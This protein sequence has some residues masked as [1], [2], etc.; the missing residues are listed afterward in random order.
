MDKFNFIEI[1]NF[2]NQKYLL[3]SKKKATKREK[4]PITQVTGK[5]LLNTLLF[6]KN[7]RKRQMQNRKMGKGRKSIS[8]KGNRNG[9]NPMTTC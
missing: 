8:Q 6:L 9:Y 3:K 5:R 7:P 4:L 2:C 1:T